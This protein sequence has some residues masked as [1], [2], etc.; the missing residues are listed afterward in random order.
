M[1][2]TVK[3]GEEMW[4]GITIISVLTH[5]PYFGDGLKALESGNAT[6]DST[7]T[8]LENQLSSLTDQRNALAGQISKLLEDAAFNGQSLNE[9]QAK[10]LID[11]GNA[12]LASIQ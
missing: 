10:S 6:D 5:I 8:K 3:L 9:Q 2:S 11:Q 7:Y 12:L 4:L 1:A